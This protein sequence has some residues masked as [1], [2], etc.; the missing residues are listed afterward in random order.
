M[1]ILALDSDN[2][3]DVGRW[4]NGL[5]HISHRF[6]HG[7]SDT[8]VVFVPTSK[9]YG[10]MGVLVYPQQTSM[11]IIFVVGFSS[12]GACIESILIGWNRNAVE[13]M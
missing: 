7:V 8:L 5:G 12:L 10:C 6:V 9:V 11:R 3:F 13:R 2:V 4:T 1:F